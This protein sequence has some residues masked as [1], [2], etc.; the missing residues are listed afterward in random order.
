MEK[1]RIKDILDLLKIILLILIVIMH[2][3]PFTFIFLALFIILVIVDKIFW[4]C[5]KC[6]NP[7]P[8][9][10]LFNTVKCC[11]YCKTDIDEK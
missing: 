5:D 3:I 6:K 11:T 4:K 1:N 9:K 2:T 8:N 7:L 10:I